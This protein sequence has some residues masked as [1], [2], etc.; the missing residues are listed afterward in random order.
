MALS[1]AR[2]VEIVESDRFLWRGGSPDA[3]N[4]LNKALP[5]RPIST[6]H[7]GIPSTAA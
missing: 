4:A 7:C 3:T 5:G 6:R 2:T 1:R